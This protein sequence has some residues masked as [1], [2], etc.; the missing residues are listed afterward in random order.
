MMFSSLVQTISRS[1]LRKTLFLLSLKVMK[2]F[3]VRFFLWQQKFAKRSRGGDLNPDL[4][5]ALQLED[6]D[7][8][9]GQ[10]PKEYRRILEEADKI[11]HHRFYLLSHN[12]SFDGDINWHLDPADG[13]EW[14]RKRYREGD[15]F[16][17]G[18]PRDP[19]LVWEL[20]R[21]QHF[22]TLA[23]SYFLTG[24]ERYS[25]EFVSQLH[26]WVDNNRAGIGINWA[27][28]LE[29]GV[30]LISWSLSLQL[31]GGSTKVQGIKDILMSSVWEQAKFL[32]ISLSL[33]KVVRS[34]HLI[35]EAGGLFI[36][37]RVF[38]F[39]ES[40]KWQAKALRV[41]A[42]E[43]AAQVHSDG[44]SKEQSTSYHR[45]VVDF[46]L[47]TYVLSLKHSLVIPQ[48]IR[49]RLEAMVEYLL[50]I[51]M[52]DGRVPFIGDGDDGRGVKLSE[53]VEF[54]DFR[55]W[56][57]A[58]AVLFDRGDLKFGA[59]D[60]TE[61]AFWLL[62]VEGF[63]KF[64]SIRTVTPNGNFKQFSSAGHY[65]IRNGWS[66]DGDFLLIRGGEFGMG[67]TGFSSHSHSDMFSPVICVA[68]EQVLID[69]GTFVYN[70]NDLDRDH[71]RSAYA[72]NSVVINS[73]DLMV[74][75]KR[76][77]WKTACDGALRT[78]DVAQDKTEIG[79]S[80]SSMPSY[81]RTV[82]YNCSSREFTI[83]DLFSDAMGEVEWFFHVAPDIETRQEENRILFF[84]QDKRVGEM[85]IPPALSPTMQDGWCSLHYGERSENKCIYIRNDLKRGD[86][87]SFRFMV[88]SKS[89]EESNRN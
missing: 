22:F 69:S 85:V 32:E 40:E 8:F 54:W 19:K 70:G 28:P 58:G 73:H 9:R 34:N 49:A 72:H 23:K 37:S 7:F 57:A 31:L 87:Y 61:E 89:R 50:H 53:S 78:L 48:I 63:R 25:E 68:G 35:G 77:G 42:R 81:C 44:V 52:P 51:Q 86:T 14:D 75:K 88:G 80:Y 16:Y 30:R 21:H 17:C 26:D 15:L 18:S 3:R 11:V 29:I 82:S 84:K 62:G 46:F 5:F 64:E 83:A 6:K 74:P 12:F 43:I 45:F 2:A 24:D 65:I 36:A 76:F 79:F 47:L 60:F 55:G 33:D 20:N 39:R 27:S 71:F 56:L 4:S 67:G 1:G 41:L 38:N 66:R 59:G 13:K 10:Y